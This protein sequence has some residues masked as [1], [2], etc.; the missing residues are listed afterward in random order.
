[1]HA[2]VEPLLQ[3]FRFQAIDCGLL[4]ENNAQNLLLEF[5][6]DVSTTRIVHRDM[7]G[8]F[9]DLAM[10]RA[11]GR[12]R[13]LTPYHS[14]DFND[15][16]E[17]CF[18]RRSFAYDFKTGEYVLREIE[19]LLASVFSVP[20]EDFRAAVRSAFRRIVTQDVEAYFG[21]ISTWWA[22]ANVHPAGGRPYI[23]MKDPKYR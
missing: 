20:T 4:P 8:T 12:T 10:R 3:C 6:G 15:D 13:V 9:K 2:L 22:Y 23:Q 1:M 21:S 5:D 18:R 7:M 14:V 11:R 17:E 19:I 16:P